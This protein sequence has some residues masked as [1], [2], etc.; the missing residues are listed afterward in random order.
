MEIHELIERLAEC[1]N[2]GPEEG[3]SA[4]DRLL[5]A[6]INNTAVTAAFEAVPRW[7]S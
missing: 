2:E 4:A 1:R 5:L 6:Y 3:H 7:Y